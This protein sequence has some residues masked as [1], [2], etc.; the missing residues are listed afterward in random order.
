MFVWLL[1]FVVSVFFLVKGADYFTEYAERLGKIIR[2]PTFIVGLV[3]VAIGTSLPELSTSI[4]SVFKGETEMVAGNVLGT[5]IANILL[6][7]G[8]AAIAVRGKIKFN[9]DLI[10]NDMPIFVTAILL[11]II[12]LIDGQFTMAEAI[13]MMLGYLVYLVYTAD[14]H[15][16]HTQELE[17]VPREKFHFKIPLLLVASLLVVFVASKFTVDAVIEMA[18]FFG[19][20]TSVVAASVLAVGTSLPEIMVAVSAAR[21]KKYDMII[22]D[23]MGSNIFDILFIFGA[24]G[25]IDTLT[26]D[27]IMITLL[28]PFL[29]GVTIVQWLILVDKK[30]TLVEGML[31]VLTYLLFLGKLLGFI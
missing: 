8:I 19:L 23:I 22:G 2:M 9:W 26:I 11:A 6:G 3:I 10:S 16:R 31:L 14:I 12:T 21:K 18:T 28:L 1:I 30:L 24:A 20:G 17:E 15:K 5:V 27:S 13:I 29:I 7:L 25:F 4:A